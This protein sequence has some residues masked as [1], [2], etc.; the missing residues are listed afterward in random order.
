MTSSKSQLLSD[1]FYSPPPS[2]QSPHNPPLL[3]GLREF[4]VSIV[5]RY[6]G[7]KDKLLRMARANKQWHQLV[8]KHYAWATFPQPGP[9]SLLSDF[10]SFFDRF[11]ELTGIQVPFF[12]GEFLNNQRLLRLGCAKQVSIQ[13]I[14]T[15]CC[16]H[17]VS[18]QALLLRKLTQLSLQSASS[19]TQFS[20][21]RLFIASL[22][23]MPSLSSL[24]F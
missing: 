6:L 16:F 19:H 9:R 7:A 1:P 4:E 10:T 14:P 22:E 24:S 23:Q 20:L 11:S 12:P 3:K 13:N 8:S 17:Q 2:F 15:L 21:F 5:A 18:D